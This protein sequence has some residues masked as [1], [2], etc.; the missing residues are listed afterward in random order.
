MKE[1]N[2]QDGIPVNAL[3]S[4]INHFVT[5]LNSLIFLSEQTITLG[6]AVF[7]CRAGRLSREFF[8]QRRLG[9]P[10]WMIAVVGSGDA[11]SEHYRVAFFEVATD[12]FCNAAVGDAGLDQVRLQCLVS[13]QQPDSLMHWPTGSASFICTSLYASDPD[14]RRLLLASCVC[15]VV[16]LFLLLFRKLRHCREGV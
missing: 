4:L 13:R 7:I 5:H 3:R 6:F 16:Q 12:N 15:L 1:C 8:V 2:D 14:L 10:V 11:L 9:W